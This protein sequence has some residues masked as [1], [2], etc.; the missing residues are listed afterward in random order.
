MKKLIVVFSLF[1]SVGAYAQTADTAKKEVKINSGVAYSGL[2]PLMIVDGVKYKG[3]IHSIKPDDIESIEVLKS[4]S[5]TS[6]YGA[7]GA[8][9]VLLITTKQGGNARKKS[10][11]GAVS[12]TAKGDSTRKV[13]YIIDGNPSDGAGFKNIKPEDIDNIS[14]LKDAS[15]TSIYGPAGKGGV[16][17]VVTKAYK[18][19][20]ADNKAETERKGKQR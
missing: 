13:L 7:E 6:L 4:S 9:G 20:Y 18:K 12:V 1:L 3:D 2:P 10:L 8:N 11:L 5:A 17:I 15:A 16:V 19:K 14:V